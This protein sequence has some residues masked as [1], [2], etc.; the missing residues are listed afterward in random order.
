MVSVPQS[1]RDGYVGRLVLLEVRFSGCYS[2]K[3][4][5]PFTI[6]FHARIIISLRTS[7]NLLALAGHLLDLIVLLAAEPLLQVVL[8]L[9]T[10]ELAEGSQ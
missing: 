5:A 10:L 9:L 2:L 3:V 6:R 8:G 1:V 4:C 7:I